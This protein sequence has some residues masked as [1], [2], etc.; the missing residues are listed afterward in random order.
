M[1]DERPIANCIVNVS[2]IF[3]V[4]RCYYL[5]QITLFRAGFKQHVEA[6]IFNSSLKHRAPLESPLNVHRLSV[7]VLWNPTRAALIK[8]YAPPR[9]PFKL[10]L[11]PGGIYQWTQKCSKGTMFG[12][13][14]P[15][16]P[17]NKIKLAI[18]S[19]C[20]QFASEV[21]PV[22]VLL[23]SPV[24]TPHFGSGTILKRFWHRAT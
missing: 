1:K 11:R 19:A 4:K 7:D 16:V 24:T 20:D 2:L 14:F 23:L 17:H 22:I 21:A 3:I 10:W 15:I 6:V 13:L 12:P 9:G 8:S 5:L 18:D